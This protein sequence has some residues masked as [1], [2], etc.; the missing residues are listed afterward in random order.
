MPGRIY[1]TGA[2]GRLG[3]AVLSKTGAVPLV[4]KKSGLKDEIVTD[5]SN[6]QLKSILKDAQAVIHLAGAIDEPK[7]K[8]M[9]E[10]NVGLTWRILNAA[11]E[12]CKIVFSSSISVYGKKL[13]RKPAD[14]ETRAA[15]DSDY[16]RS[17]LEAEEMVRKRRSHVILR[18]GPIYGPQFPD[19]FLIL[20]RIKR[21]RMRMVGDGSSRIPFVH[22]DDVAAVIA[23]A[24]E[25]GQG[26]YVVA[27]DPL[28]QDE[29]FAIAAKELG[30]EAPRKKIPLPL[31]MA[32]ARA[33]SFVSRAA[34]RKPKITAEHVA[35]LGYDRIFDCAKARKE[36]GF[37]PRPLEQGIREMV[38]AYRTIKR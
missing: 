7:R 6:E 8:K 17:K 28:R 1:L 31:A 18:I 24:L 35:I 32:A 2:T 21:G 37:S 19:Y 33:G 13:A 26:T 11:P 27:G 22:V 38:A 3:S 36:L 5:F 16:S 23:S 9:N 30:V 14:E 4:R 20:D 29:I 34:G 25:A 12:R 15:P 10:T